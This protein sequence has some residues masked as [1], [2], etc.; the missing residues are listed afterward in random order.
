MKRANGTGSI[1]KRNDT[2]RRNPYC[3][4]L[5]GGK[6][7][8]GKRIRTFLGS[9]PTHRQAQDALE[10]YRQGTL[11][12]P[13]NNVP[14][15]EVW[16]IYKEDKKALTGS[17]NANYLST[18]KLY[19]APRLGNEPVS[20]IKTMHM[21]A[22]I[23]ACKSPATQGFIRSIFTGLFSY[24]V[25]N[26]LAIKDYSAALKTERPQKSTLHKPFA[27]AEMR[28]LWNNADKDIIKIFLIQTYTGT[29]KNELAEIL[30]ENVNL[31][32]Q[33]MI[34]G[35]KTAA[36][37]NRIIPIADCILPLVRHFYSISRFAGYK[38]LIMPN[39]QRGIVKYGEIIHLAYLYQKYFPA[40]SSHDARHTFI[41][42]CS[43]YG[44]PESVVKKIVGHVGSDTTASVYTHK[45]TQQLLDVVNSLPFG[46]EMYIN[47]SEKSGS[48]VVATK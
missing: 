32:E 13:S 1:V 14:L 28:W 22:C 20:N 7:D 23:N 11:I 15:K 30:M 29:R 40:H 12:K 2:K 5:D 19:I 42:M 10:Q 46:T 47:P 43:N 3:V 44:Q 21:Q 39:K 34:G 17:I 27:T 36:G 31:K 9:Y 6:D 26:D 16:E 38:Y 24:A 18:W 41:T 25:A 33:Y 48:H 4:Y 45:S 8:F 37:K 35:L